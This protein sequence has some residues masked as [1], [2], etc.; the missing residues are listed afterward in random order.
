MESINPKFVGG[1]S[2]GPLGV[3]IAMPGTAPGAVAVTVPGGG[4]AIVNITL[5]GTA[6]RFDAFENSHLIINDPLW[7]WTRREDPLAQAVEQ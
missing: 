2:V 7:I 1:S 5:Q 6:Q 3:P 4:T